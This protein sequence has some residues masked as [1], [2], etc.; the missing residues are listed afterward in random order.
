MLGIYILGILI[1]WN[2]LG[3]RTLIYPIK[4]LVVA[5]HEFW[6]ILVGVC[7][8]QRLNSIVLDPTEGGRTTFN[9]NEPIIQPLQPVACYWAAMVGNALIGSLLVFCGFNTLASKVASFFIGLSFAAV[10][11]GSHLP[12]RVALTLMLPS[13]ILWYANGAIMLALTAAWLGLM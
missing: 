12:Q 6:H 10:S 2:I 4:M 8:G 9:E 3:L 5:Y 13:Q 1:A 11:T 7:M